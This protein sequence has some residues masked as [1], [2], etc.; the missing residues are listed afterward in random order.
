M[1]KKRKGKRVREEERKAMKKMVEE[2][3]IQKIYCEMFL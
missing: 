1:E 3:Q 2:S